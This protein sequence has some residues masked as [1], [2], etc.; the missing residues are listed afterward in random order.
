[1]TQAF[2]VQIDTHPGERAQDALIRALEQILAAADPLYPPNG[3]LVL[4]VNPVGRDAID[5]GMPTLIG[6]DRRS[7]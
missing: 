2:V 4:R 6:A 5:P 1:M 7:A 3:L